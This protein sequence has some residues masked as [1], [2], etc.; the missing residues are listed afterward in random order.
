MKKNLVR[1]VRYIY[2]KTSVLMLFFGALGLPGIRFFE[3]TGDNMFD[4][5]LNGALVGQV[6]DAEE[7]E[8]CMTR[9]RYAVSEQSDEIVFMKTELALEGREVLFG[10]ISRE[11]D[12][13]AQMQAVMENSREETMQQAYTVKIN[14]FTVNLSS[15]IGRASCRERV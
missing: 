5:Y 6:A 10:E 15:K 13:V 3:H 12:I 9:A 11:E 1:K 14:N 7:A 4:V 2:F 8:N